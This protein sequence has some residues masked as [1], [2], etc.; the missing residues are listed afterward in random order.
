[1]NACALRWPQRLASFAMMALLASGCAQVE[2]A[3]QRAGA[4][5]APRN[6]DALVAGLDRAGRAWRTLAQ[7]GASDADRAKAREACR[8][9]TG[10]FVVALQRRHA[11]REWRGTLGLS[12]CGE[13][14]ALRFDDARGCWQPE[15]FDRFA[16]AKNSRATS[17]SRPGGVG[18]PLVAMREQNR[19]RRATGP[20]FPDHG[21]FLPAT[22]TLEFG[23]TKRGAPQPVTLR[24]FDPRE[25]RTTHIG[26]RAEPLAA[27]FAT[28]ARRS[29]GDSSLKK[30]ALPGFLWPWRNFDR[31]G[32]CLLEPY[33]RDKVPILM[34][35]GLQSDPHIWEH[36]TAA[37][38]ADPE[39]AARCQLWYFAYPTGL[40]VPG[41]AM[42]LRNAM[43]AVRERYDPKHH[44][45]GISHMILVGHSMGGLLCRM[46][47]IDSGDAFWNA[48]FKRRP[49][50][51]H[52]DAR[53]Q[54]FVTGALFF[55]H[56]PN[57]ARVIFICTPHC[58]SQI[59]DWN[60][61]RLA[62]WLVSIPGQTLTSITRI[63]ALDLDALNPALQRFR[64]L[65]TTSIDT[66]SPRHPYFA[67]LASRPILVPC[68]SIIGDRGRG[69]SP[70]SSDGVVPYWSSHLD[71]A[72][73]EKIVPCWHVCVPKPAVV[74]QVTRI[75]RE[76]LTEKPR[77][78]P[79][80]Q[81][82]NSTF[83]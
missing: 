1:M 40:P 38:M 58:G 44:D 59:A 72:T 25:Q 51:M 76:R 60:I 83:Q 19:E 30:L 45:P 2:H 36:E 63:A 75:V 28:P 43:G 14:F 68:D 13:S 4:A 24:L 32:I 18:A 50:E 49:E 67:A 64:N 26:A 77:A 34:V 80:I 27:D 11:T 39:I 6:D 78:T 7:P 41:S 8:D 69:D 35:H 74:E 73:S 42:Q 9:A 62:S 37:L 33:R 46:Q 65:G 70:G 5:F 71:A 48:Y 31:N 81:S 54:R 66:L 57:V 17:A 55:Q 10:R 15:F 21:L 20:F 16:V 56:Q 53:T 82:L 12:A 47:V 79:R 61:G 52:F 3:R 22:A 23:D 29:L